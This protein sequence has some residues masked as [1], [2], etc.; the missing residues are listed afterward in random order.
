MQ[1]I[2]NKG[3]GVNTGDRSEKSVSRVLLEQLHSIGIKYAFI[4]SGTD[5]AP[6][7]ESLAEM[8]L[9]N[10][11][12]TEVILVPHE[13]PAVAMAIGYYMIAHTPAAVMVHTT[14]GTANSLNNIL[15]A[16]SMNIPLMLF[17]GRTP[18]TEKAV[19]G[20][21]EIPV[22]W[23]QEMRDQGAIL[24]QFT[25]W[26]WEHRFGEQVGEEL[27]RAYEV[28]M[29]DPKGPVYMTLPRERI[30]EKAPPATPARRP[31]PAEPVVPSNATIQKVA[32]LIADAKKPLI[33]TSQLGRNL[34]APEELLKLSE[35]MA[36][37]VA[38]NFYYMNFPT[39]SQMF[40]GPIG[41]KLFNEH[42]K[43]AD[44]LLVL[45]VD[46]PWF[47]NSVEPDPDAT[48]VHLDVDPMKERMPTWGFRADIR[49][50]A[51]AQIA[52]GMLNSEVT[53]K[54]GK[55]SETRKTV[56]ARRSTVSREHDA[57]LGSY[58][59]EA[60]D[61]K[62]DTP[63][64]PRWLSY[65]IGTIL[66][67]RKIVFTETVRSPFYE[68]APVSSF[69][70]TFSTPP[71]GGLGWSMGAALGAKLASPDSD[72]LVLL[73]DGSYMYNE[74]VASHFVSRA[75]KLPI[76]TVIYN[77]QAWMASRGPVAKMYPEGKAVK[78][79]NFPGTVLS[80]SPAFE[81]VAQSCGAYTK[82][83]ENPDEIMSALKDSLDHM[84]ENENQALLNVIL[85][86]P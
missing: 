38:Q 18:V 37:P 50:R 33:I 13:G 29:S 56:E 28:A 60:K 78:T 22:H 79:H 54:M 35:S 21:K 63:I 68:Y 83:V 81:H 52:L 30:S 48:V 61:H 74:P 1:T 31:S 42:L 55:S 67:D 2:T 39:T 65:C 76:M 4:N 11:P 32:Q 16:Q 44:L 45:D 75:S 64:D 53:G 17:A 46:V 80:P 57:M 40:V 9:E 15:N 27:A 10:I 24:R 71:F 41:G 85:K 5:Y 14:P 7:I 72:V 62:D 58:M 43:S 47:P 6:I 25:K 19:F 59:K 84:H 73:G 86:H 66:D 77:N 34:G 12:M 49:I 70:R 51:D 20:S 82:R 69:G 23:N 3:N 36:I 8:S 26:D